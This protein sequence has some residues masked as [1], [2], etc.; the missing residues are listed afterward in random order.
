MD[1]VLPTL[2]EHEKNPRWIMPEKSTKWFLSRDPPSNSFS[3]SG[4]PFLDEVDQT[5]EEDFKRK[6]LETTC[7]AASLRR[8]L[9][10]PSEDS[11]S[12]SD[13]ADDDAI[14]FHRDSESSPEPRYVVGKSIGCGGMGS[15]YSGWDLRLQRPVAIKIIHERERGRRSGLLRFLR[16][17][18]IASR[19]QHPGIITIHDFDVTEEGSAFIVMGLVHGETLKKCLANR[20]NP[21]SD[22]AHLMSIFLQVCQT[23]AFSHSRGTV[24]RDLKPSNIMIGEFGVV[25]ILD[26]G[27]SKVVDSDALTSDF[28]DL[29]WDSC[30]HELVE[31]PDPKFQVDLCDTSVGTVMGTLS[32]LSPEQARGETD[33]VDKRSDV[34]GLGSILCEILTGLPPFHGENPTVLWA[35]ATAGDVN[36]ALESLDACGAPIPMVELAKQCLSPN[37]LLRPRD[38]S[39]LVDT[40]TRYFEAQHRNAEQDLVRFFDLSLD[41]FCIANFHGY[42]VR[43]NNNFTQLLGYSAEELTQCSFLEFVHPED[44]AKTQKEV[45]KLSAGQPTN[46][47]V[48]RYR[49]K[50]GGY[51]WLEW[52]ARSV[53]EESSVYAVA[54]HVSEP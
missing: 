19:L 33:R 29:E 27:L 40:L 2:P 14:I 47:F 12:D 25:T 20:S 39:V 45:E 9:D 49:H 53:L 13:S 24:H 30:D 54:R 48:N 1:L 21:R 23:V 7:F 26:W 17:A 18:R 11:E 8:L 32:Y 34:F 31:E 16:E 37:P 46:Q 10:A 44:Y 6:L 41:L 22:L 50:L 15:V 5:P 28:A 3:L 42:F 35:A 43:V 38:A 52:S 51:L 36:P 4:E